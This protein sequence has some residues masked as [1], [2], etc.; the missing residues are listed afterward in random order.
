MFGISSINRMYLQCIL[1]MS[2][3]IPKS[4]FT[5]SL[6]LMFTKKQNRWFLPSTVSMPLSLEKE[7]SKMISPCNCDYF[8]PISNS[9]SFTSI[10]L[11]IWAWVF[12]KIVVPQNGWFIMEN[13]TKMDDF[14]VPLFLETPI[15]LLCTLPI[16]QETQGSKL[17]CH[18]TGPSSLLSRLP[19]RIPGVSRWGDWPRPGGP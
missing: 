1:Y 15:C 2:V 4:W 19:S 16:C 9:Y 7:K 17:L 3:C 6:C 10:G 18:G 14:G 13:P 12:P 8:N 11:A 5:V